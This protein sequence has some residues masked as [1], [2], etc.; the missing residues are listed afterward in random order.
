MY[1]SSYSFYSVAKLEVVSFLTFAF[2]LYFSLG[3]S[4]AIWP[5]PA[6]VQQAPVF[7]Y[8]LF[9]V[10]LVLLLSLFFDLYCG[11]L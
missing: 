1:T 10:K 3:Q 5:S 8:S 6:Q 2:P 7:L 9:L 11:F 4:F